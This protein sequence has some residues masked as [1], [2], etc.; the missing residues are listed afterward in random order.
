MAMRELPAGDMERDSTLTAIYRAAAQDAPPAALDAAILAAARREV[1]ARPRPA[2]LAFGHSWRMPLSLAAVIVLS[3][4]LVTLVREEAPELTEPPRAGQ[5]T[6]DPERK[7]AASADSG[8]AATAPG[9]VPD[10]Q[11][12]KSIGLKPPQPMSSPGLGMRQPESAER[13]AQPRKEKL[14]DRQEADAPASTGF[15]KRRDAPAN[16]MEQQND[17]RAAT[18]PPGQSA[19][20][21]APM[22]D[23]IAQ[24]PPAASA[25]SGVAETKTLSRSQAAD[26]DRPQRDARLRA[27][28]EPAPVAEKQSA[29]APRTPD[30]ETRPAANARSASP[31]VSAMGKLERLELPPEK[32]LERIEE[33]RRQGKFDEAKASLAE[34]RKRFPDYRLPEALRDWGNP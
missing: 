20:V 8:A 6:A 29:E 11:R 5:P 16:V 24:Q 31:A 25:A 19:A 32:W 14:A 7:P 3:V 15:A 13:G 26:S 4:S 12:S 21:T 30:V 27:A 23:S 18:P 17:K 1:G 33:L 28:P 22:M 2:G 10:A 34:F 9:F